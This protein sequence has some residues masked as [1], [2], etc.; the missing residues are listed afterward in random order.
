MLLI[1]ANIFVFLTPLSL[2][3]SLSLSL[4]PGQFALFQFF[5]TFYFVIIESMQNLQFFY[6]KFQPSDFV[7][8]FVIFQVLLS[9]KIFINSHLG[10][11][12]V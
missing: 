3:L 4:P 10:R 9:P 2:S 8:L 12:L 1:Y 11:H 6:H 5:C 7:K